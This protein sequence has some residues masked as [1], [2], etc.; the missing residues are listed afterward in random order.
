MRVLEIAPETSRVR[1]GTPFRSR[2]AD[3]SWRRRQHSKTYPG[4]VIK[5]GPDLDAYARWVRRVLKVMKDERGWGIVRVA[6]EGGV[7][8]AM[9]TNWRDANWTQGKP[10]RASVEKFCDNLKLKKDEPFGLLRLALDPERGAAKGDD[11]LEAEPEDAGLDH[12]IKL[13]ELRL[14]Q[15]PPAP[16]RRELEIALVAAKRLR[17]SGSAM[18]DEVLQKYKAG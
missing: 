9:L 4:L 11:L 14:S 12:R 15:N 7:S 3:S 2:D 17:D 6:S 8:R 13:L 16:E 5:T 1:L 18:I 10:T